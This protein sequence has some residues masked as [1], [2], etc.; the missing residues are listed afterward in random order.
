MKREDACSLETDAIL[1]RSLRFADPNLET[2]FQS[3]RLAT[4]QDSFKPVFAIL[5]LVTLN[6]LYLDHQNVATAQ[7]ATIYALRLAILTSTSLGLGLSLRKL[8]DRWVIWLFE[9]ILILL[10]VITLLRA[11]SEPGYFAVGMIIQF[12]YILVVY[13]ISPF[14]WLRQ[15]TYAGLFSLACIAMWEYRID[16]TTDFNRLIPSYPC[17]NILGALLAR[18]RHLQERHLFASERRRGRQLVL[19]EQLQNQQSEVLDLLTHELRHP[20]ANIAAQGE[21]I[22]RLRDLEPIH[23]AAARIVKASTDSASIIR[24]WI[25]GDRLVT[26]RKH[27][28][29]I[30]HRLLPKPVI[31]EIVDNFSL[32]HPDVNITI[33]GDDI[34]PVLMDKRVFVLAIQNVLENAVRYASSGH[35]IH[36]QFRVHQTNV[37][38]RIRDYGPGLSVEDQSRI[39]LKHV[40]LETPMTPTVGTGIGLYLVTELLSRCGA[41]IRVQ[42]AVGRGTAFLIEIPRAL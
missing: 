10:M 5:M 4:L 22:L 20:L 29:E 24:D 28:G 39:F 15:L 30:D 7:T 27:E 37:T 34:P 38:V 2:A 25:D 1:A 17:A 26:R 36:I 33:T 14:N 12:F 21:L 3:W 23:R 13:L 11:Y 32:D 35:G 41:R 16:Y 6:N 31:G 40:T 19:V 42:S 8:N 18:Q 9:F